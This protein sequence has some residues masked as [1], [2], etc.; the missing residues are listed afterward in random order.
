MET[1]KLGEAMAVNNT[2]KLMRIKKL[3]ENIY[4]GVLFV[5]S[6]MFI[7]MVSLGILQVFCRYAL[8][9][10]LSFTEELGR[11]LFIWVTFLGTVLALKKNKH[12]NMELLVLQFPKKLQEIIKYL[13]FAVTMGTYG[14]L[15]YSGLFIVGKTMKQTSA[16]MNM[17]MG[18]VYAAVPISVVIMVIFEMIKLFEYKRLKEMEEN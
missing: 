17:P 15:I 6:T 3:E 13:V 1:N 12:V 18:I 5:S 10:S 4:K 11:F 2:E 14:V 8:K 16:A 9:I 7:T